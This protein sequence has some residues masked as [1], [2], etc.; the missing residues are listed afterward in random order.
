MTEQLDR[1][2]G[3]FGDEYTERNQVN[4]TTRLR[5]WQVMLE[6]LMLYSA[7]EIGANRG[8]NLEAIVKTWPT[9]IRLDGIEPNLQ[10]AGGAF[11]RPL[12]EHLYI[13]SQD[14]VRYATLDDLQESGTYD[15]VFTCGVLIHVPPEELDKALRQIYR[16]SRRYILAIEYYAEQETMIPYRGMDNMLWKR[17]YEQEY[18]RRYGG[19]QL[20]TI[21]SGFW[22]KADGFDDCHWWL[23]EKITP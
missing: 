21:R 5:A 10:A 1:W 22:T 6:G 11:H 8:A 23:M 19:S 15:L 13:R 18:L 7:L 20:H 12:S 16:L 2:R 9:F 17:N 3:A 14:G 4:Y